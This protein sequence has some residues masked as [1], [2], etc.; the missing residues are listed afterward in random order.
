[1]ATELG[2]A[3]ISVGL[4]TNKLGSDIRQAFAGAEASGVDAGRSAGSGFGRA[5]SLAATAFAALGVGS[6]LKSSITEASGLGESINALDV[7]FG[8]ASGGV[9]QLGKDAAKS[10]GLSNLEFNSLAV[11]FSS[12]AETISGPGGDVTSTLDEMTTRASDFASVMNLDVSQAAELFQSGLAGETEPLRAFGLDM[13]AAAVE[14]FAL[15]SGLVT[16][17]TAMTEAQKVQARYG[18]LM[19][20]TS[21]TQGDFANT[22]GSL[23][24][25][26]RI[27][28]SSWKNTQ[29]SLGTLFLP[30]LEKAVGFIVSNVLPVVDK[31]IANLGESGLAGAF[32]PLAS[33][34]GPI[35]LQVGGAVGELSGALWG[36][37][38]GA[39]PLLGPLIAGATGVMNFLAENTGILTAAVI[40]LA[41]GMVVWRLAQIAGNI[42]A[43]ASVP[44]AA[45]QAASNFTLAAAIR[46]QTAAQVTDTVATA[47][48]TGS[49]VAGIGALIANGAALVASR[50]A[51]LA[52][53]AATGVATAAQ[54]AWNAAL[55]ANPIGIVIVA[56]AALVGALVWF[57]TQT[58]AGRA[59]FQSVFAFIQSTV[60]SVVRWFMGTLVPTFQR[61]WSSVQSGLGALGGFFSSTWSNVLGNVGGFIGNLVGIFSSLP[62]RIMG[63]LGGLAGMLVGVGRNMVQGLIDG[64][65]G[66]IGNAVQAVKNVGGAMLDG[67]K[68]FLGIKSPSRVFK[69]EVGMMIGAGVIAGVDASKRGVDSSIRGLVSVPSVPS[70][71]ASSYTPAGAYGSGSGATFNTTINQVDD[72]IGTSHA[73]QR[74]LTALA[75]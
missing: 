19:S 55:T 3:F 6:F 22:S 43:L 27:L 42:A 59:I 5:F 34:A 15:E 47:A 63:A 23:A 14:A 48:N 72:P 13:S 49:R 26:T 32:A 52:A 60:N 4:G 40:A 18:L 11:R 7:T 73:V 35:L 50:V 44:I 65:G 10:L 51:Q 64:V 31:L 70:F 53:S 62:G 39:L 8:K 21:K 37:V 46:A 1:M 41:A 33:A 61:V 29:A 68:G 36:L 20:Q 75:V 17:G 54:W 30:V 69:S 67:I 71:R 2:S 9:Q 45:A 16:A 74:R 58:E 38:A 12:F 28:S 24:N 57:F 56:I 66:M 25:Q